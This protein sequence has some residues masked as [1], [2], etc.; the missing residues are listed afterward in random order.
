[1]IFFF[2]NSGNSLKVVP[3]KVYQGSNKSNTIYFCMPTSVGQSV[4]AQFLLST[5]EILAQQ[6]MAAQGAIIGVTYEDKAVNVWTLD[7]TDNVTAWAG[8]V[9]VQFT[10]T[11][12]DVITATAS[13]E[14]IV[15]KGVPKKLPVPTADQQATYDQIIETLSSIQGTVIDTN[16]TTGFAFERIPNTTNA[17]VIGWSGVIPAGRLRVAPYV[18]LDGVYLKV[19]EYGKESS[20]TGVVNTTNVSLPDTLETIKTNSFKVENGLMPTIIP[21]SVRTIEANA[22]IVTPANSTL[23]IQAK[24]FPDSIQASSFGTNDATATNATV[25]P[26]NVYTD[27]TYKDLWKNYATLAKDNNKITVITPVTTNDVNEILIDGEYV[28]KGTSDL[29]NYYLKSQTYNQAEIEE[30]LANVKSTV[31]KVV[32]VLPAEGEDNVIYL[33]PKISNNPT[34]QEVTSDD[35][36][37]GP[38]HLTFSE[39]DAKYIKVNGATVA[40]G[41]QLKNGDIV[42]VMGFGI[43][44]QPYQTFAVPIVN[45]AT[46]KTS[47]GITLTNT[48]INV[49][50]YDY[51]DELV[52]LTI[53]FVMIDTQDTY[54]EWIWVID[55]NTDPVTK[56]WE[57]IGT[58]A[59]DLSNYPTKT[60]MNA[61]IEAAISQA[62]SGITA[63]DLSYGAVNVTYDNT[64]GALLSSTARITT[65]NTHSDV[66]VESEM[67]IF[68]DNNDITIDANT[69][70]TGLIIKGAEIL[71]LNVVPGATSGTLTQL[72]LDFLQ[73]KKGNMIMVDHELYRLGSD[74]YNPGFLTYYHVGITGTTQHIKTVSITLSTRAWT[75]VVKE[76][77]EALGKAG[78]I[79]LLES[80]WLQE[81][82][83]TSYYQTK[84]FAVNDGDAV[85]F[86]PA[87]LGARNIVNDTRLFINS[88]TTGVV[89]FTAFTQPAGNLTL[90]FFIARGE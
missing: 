53:N 60:E 4:H 76:V 7:I 78:S 56:K 43:G 36:Y 1:M 40:S 83:S 59:I 31:F 89:V 37:A 61:A 27:L 68:G 42:T 63:L 9:T 25:A 87:T 48:D 30:K 67:P 72:Q 74:G 15:T 58:T 16:S 18:L 17:R 2:D 32:P 24:G 6:I 85:F 64:D 50:G 44:Q 52:T 86:T 46:Y 23:K 82:G 3:E 90:N 84:N 20:T 34:T 35:P 41:Y 80:E 88:T 47:Q 29:E 54:D 5:G 75:I 70:G 11:L 45:G 22:F 77:Q 14:F 21:D 73:N 28:T 38:F 33:T 57:H 81:S 55:P 69:A 66:P 19:T 49:S 79:T 26:V 62:Q 39:D 13:G 8:K 10:V 51:A 71:D 65:G 12:G